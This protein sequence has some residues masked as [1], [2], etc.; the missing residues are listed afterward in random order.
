MKKIIAFAAL[1]LGMFSAQAQGLEIG[2]KV[3]PA[4]SNHRFSSP[5]GFDFKNENMKFR[6]SFGLVFDYFFGENY[7]FNT[8]LEYAVRGG[9]ISYKPAPALSASRET[10][11]LNIQ[12]L[13]LPVGIKLFTN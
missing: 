3:S 5:G 7:A 12:Y 11:E 4:G 13:R 1:F 9:K 2:I 10:D 8:G 6:G